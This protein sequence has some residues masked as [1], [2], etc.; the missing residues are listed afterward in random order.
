MIHPLDGGRERVVVENKGFLFE[1]WNFQL[2]E[3]LLWRGLKIRKWKIL[4][5]ISSRENLS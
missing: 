3:C 5:L 1:S 4:D 2:K